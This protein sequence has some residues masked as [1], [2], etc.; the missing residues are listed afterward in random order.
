MGRLNEQGLMSRLHKLA[1]L[2][3]LTV[4]HREEKGENLFSFVAPNRRVY[5]IFTYR[6]AK[7]FAKGIQLGRTLHV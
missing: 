6:K 2:S 1:E 5:D 7:T 4:R 3:G